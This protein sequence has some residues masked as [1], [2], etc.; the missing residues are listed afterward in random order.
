MILIYI[1]S[2]VIYCILGFVSDRRVDL[3]QI[4]LLAIL[5]AAVIAITSLLSSAV[6]TLTSLLIITLC[7]IAG[8]IV[9]VFCK[10]N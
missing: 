3:L 9:G 2:F 7:T 5:I 8:A 10:Q 1:L 6:L 4:I